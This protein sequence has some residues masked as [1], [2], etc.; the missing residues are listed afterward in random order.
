[1]CNYALLIIV[2]WDHNIFF[3]TEKIPRKGLIGKID[4]PPYVTSVTHL[5]VTIGVTN[6]ILHMH[7]YGWKS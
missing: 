1:M 3:L 4:I 7:V 6:I 5:N 2:L